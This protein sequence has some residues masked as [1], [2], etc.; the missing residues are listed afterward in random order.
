MV[1]N[2]RQAHSSSNPIHQSGQHYSALRKA[3]N[4]TTK[5]QWSATNKSGLQQITYCTYSTVEGPSESLKRMGFRKGHS[6]GN[7][8]FARKVSIS[9]IRVELKVRTAPF[10]T[11][12]L[13][14]LRPVKFEKSVPPDSVC[15]ITSSI[16]TITNYAFAMMS[17]IRASLPRSF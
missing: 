17:F 4:A 6:D 11:L 14:L 9:T 8:E 16:F 3:Y 5:Q 1:T 2:A 12:L 7:L 15:K 10:E 13:T